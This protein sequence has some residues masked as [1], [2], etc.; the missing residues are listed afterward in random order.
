[1]LCPAI[2]ASLCPCARH[3]TLRRSF[4]LLQSDQCALSRLISSLPLISSVE[5]SRC[6][7]HESTDHCCT[8][9]CHSANPTVRV[10]VRCVWPCFNRNHYRH[11]LAVRRGSRRHLA[12][13]E[14]ATSSNELVRVV[15]PSL[16]AHSRDAP[17]SSCP[18]QGGREGCQVGQSA[19][20]LP[21]SIRHKLVNE[22]R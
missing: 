3:W 17:V 6:E 1:M 7:T 21:L 11:T 9:H 12:L 18:S 2:V 5:A 13:P 8:L 19:R 20:P 16:A 4:S 14:L 15:G 10:L 22:T